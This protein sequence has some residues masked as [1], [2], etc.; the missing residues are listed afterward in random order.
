MAF[1]LMGDNREAAAQ[2]NALDR[3]ASKDP[4]EYLVNPAEAFVRRRARAY[5]IAGAR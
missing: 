3:F 4:W 2:F 5:A 1:S